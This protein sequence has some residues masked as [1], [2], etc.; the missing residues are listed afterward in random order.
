MGTGAVTGELLLGMIEEGGLKGAVRT[1]L[2]LLL[3]WL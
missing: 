3:G 2:L 1:E